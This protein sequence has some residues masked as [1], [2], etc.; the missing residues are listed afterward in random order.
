MSVYKTKAFT[1]R[2]VGALHH[3]F[4][5]F[6]RIAKAGQI[7]ER[8]DTIT[9]IVTEI[10]P[11]SQAIGISS[12]QRI[13]EHI[14]IQIEAVSILCWIPIEPSSREGV[15]DAVAGVVCAQ[16]LVP[17]IASIAE[18][19]SSSGVDSIRATYFDTEVIA[20]NEY[21]ITHYNM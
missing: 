4:P 12:E 9:Q 1:L 10:A 20:M 21:L 15:V 17:S 6:V 16:R 14:F 3:V 18:E 2:P 13:A 7:F 8:I 5:V 11:S 19:R